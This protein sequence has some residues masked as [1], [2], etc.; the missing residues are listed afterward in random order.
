MRLYVMRH[1]DAGIHVAKAWSPE[2]RNRP[3][4]DEGVE[5]AN[6]I[7]QWLVDAG[8]TPTRVL[9]SPV[10]RAVETGRIVAGFFEIKPEVNN[11]LDLEHPAEMLVRQLADQRVKRALIVAHS[12]NLEPA[13][14][15]LNA[16]DP[17]DVDPF[18]TGELRIL[19]VKPKAVTWKEKRRVTPN[20]LGI[21]DFDQY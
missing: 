1:A 16:I 3:L 17:E 10:A 11:T 2:D 19:R 5:Q 12:D 6:A 13:L 20:D 9:T 21:G 7:G 15:S 18:A 8:E 14:A 4:T